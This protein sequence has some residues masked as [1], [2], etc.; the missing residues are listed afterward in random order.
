M[1]IKEEKI[2]FT[3]KSGSV[4]V[5]ERLRTLNKKERHAALA[6]HSGR[7]PYTSLVAFALTPDG[8]GVLFATPRKTTKYKN[9]MRNKNV[10]FL[11]DTRA[12][13][14]KGYMD[15]EAVTILGTAAPIRKGK[16]RDELAGIF[17]RKHP[18]LAEF[19]NAP[20]TAMVF[21]SIQKIIHAGRFQ[22]VTEWKNKRA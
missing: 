21:V 18:E 17:I 22:R 8:G 19:V 10:S 13:T 15:S 1:I 12:N 20:S 3:K 16:R 7:Q 9:I 11:I 2:P 6:T 5:P 14:P 4:D